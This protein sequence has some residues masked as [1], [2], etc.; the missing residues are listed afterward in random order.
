MN[1]QKNLNYYQQKVID[2]YLA[3]CFLQEM[4][5]FK[6]C[7]FI[8]QHFTRQNKKTQVLNMLLV[9]NQKEYIMIN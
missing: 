7:L 5:D 3:K 4:V 8:N 2:F 6:I 9:E 1:Y